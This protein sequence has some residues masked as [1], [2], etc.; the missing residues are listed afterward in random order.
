M[1]AM[2]TNISSIAAATSSLADRVKDAVAQATG[3]LSSERVARLEDMKRRVSELSARGLLRK[4][5]YTESS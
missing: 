2:T 4:Q 5:V 3:A 1:R